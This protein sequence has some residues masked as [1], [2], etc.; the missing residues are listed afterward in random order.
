MDNA[1]RSDDRPSDAGGLSQ[2]DLDV[3][4]RGI[5]GK[6]GQ[7]AYAGR[8][9]ALLAEPKTVDANG[10]RPGTATGTRTTSTPDRPARPK[11]T[12]NG[13]LRPRMAGGSAC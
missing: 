7:F 10:S 9:L 3:S 12:S 6:I 4:R 13:R 5:L 11:S 1:K 2:D 8:A